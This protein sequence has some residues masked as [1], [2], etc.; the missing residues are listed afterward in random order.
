MTFIYTL[1]D[2]LFFKWFF[3]LLK[4]IFIVDGLFFLFLSDEGRNDRQDREDNLAIFSLDSIKIK[5]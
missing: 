2:Q 5:P 4:G 3:K 1:F